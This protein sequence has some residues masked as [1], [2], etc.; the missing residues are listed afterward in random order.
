MYAFEVLVIYWLHFPRTL[1]EPRQ[2][3]IDQKEIG[4]NIELHA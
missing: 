2:A 4:W 1:S 3:E